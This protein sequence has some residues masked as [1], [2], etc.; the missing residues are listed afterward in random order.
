MRAV[1]R[2]VNRGIPEKFSGGALSQSPEPSTP[3]SAHARFER[4]GPKS[5][6]PCFLNHQL[7]LEQFG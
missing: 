6:P 1:I 7:K 4:V 2:A 5:A 3:N